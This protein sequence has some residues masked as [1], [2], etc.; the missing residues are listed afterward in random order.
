MKILVTGANGFIGS[1]VVQALVGM[2]QYT[3]SAACRGGSVAFNDK[4]RTFEVGDIS[5]STKWQEALAGVDA[6]IHTAARVHIKQETSADPL[7]EFRKVNADGTLNLALQAAALD[8]KRFIYIS[9]I[10]VNGEKT[11]LNKPFTEDDIPS[12][13]GPY[14]ISKYEAE[15]SLLRLSQESNMEVVIIRPP[16]VYGP[17]VT[18]NYLS[19]MKWIGRGLPLPFKLANNKR[20]FVGSGNLVSLLI[21]CIDHPLAANQVFLVSD[22]EDLSMAELVNRIGRALGVKP[23]LLPVPIWFLRT[24][25]FL[26]GK[27]SITKRLCDSLQVDVTKSYNLLGW[28]PPYSIEEELE[29]TVVAFLR[30]EK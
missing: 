14:A 26:F 7:S 1:A 15:Q 28:S 10:K 18:A 21:T 19:L 27:Y 24:I 3:I 11:E 22:G 16:L 9:S 23:M 17:E 5:L 6:V 4:I 25:A 8:V 12:P 20:S 13:N 29:K 30:S 2:N